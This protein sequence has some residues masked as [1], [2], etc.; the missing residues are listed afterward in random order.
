MD[1]KMNSTRNLYLQV[2][3]IIR[4]EEKGVELSGE[5]MQK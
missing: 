1:T 3:D 2:D 5:K 4:F